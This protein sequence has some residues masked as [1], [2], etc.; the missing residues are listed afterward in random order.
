VIVKKTPAQIEKMHR[1][2]MALAEVMEALGG[3]AH[4]GVR[5]RDLDALAEGMIRERGGEPSFL[6]YRGHSGVIPFP[7]SICAS[8][9]DVIVHGIPDDRELMEGDILSVDVGLSIDGWHADTAYTYAVGDISPEARRLLEVTEGALFEGIKHCRPGRRLSDYAHAVERVVEAAGFSV[10]REFVGHG[11]GRSMH[12]D[13]QIPNFGPP[14]RGPVLEAGMVLA[15]E[16]MVNAGGWKTRTLDDGW[17]VVTE[18]G[19]LSAHFEHTVAVTPAGPLILT[20]RRR[21]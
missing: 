13:P 6:G 3:A 17:T 16:P 9:N 20:A 2:G 18:D 21:D 14:G 10:V 7:G 1:A 11:I 8:P 4:P 5:M 12:E 15:L 19:S